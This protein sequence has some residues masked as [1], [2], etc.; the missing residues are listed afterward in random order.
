MELLF[1]L[2]PTLPS[3]FSPSSGTTTTAPTTHQGGHLRPAP[4]QHRYALFLL[5]RNRSFRPTSAHLAGRTRECTSAVRRNARENSPVTNKSKKK[6]APPK[7][8]ISLC[9]QDELWKVDRALRPGTGGRDRGRDPGDDCGRESGA[10]RGARGESRSPEADGQLRFF[11]VRVFSTK[12]EKLT[13]FS[14]HLSLDPFF[15]LP[16]KNQNSLFSLSLPS[17]L[18]PLKKTIN[19]SCWRRRGWRSRGQEARQGVPGAEGERRR[20]RGR[21]W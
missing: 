5:R 1:P 16:P 19:N 4:H 18:F 9:R 10:G 6:I 7:K 8:K 2:S 14:L 17:L 12:T 20:R 21:R 11:R 3:T 15:P 13:F